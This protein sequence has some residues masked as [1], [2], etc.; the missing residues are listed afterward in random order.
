M[1]LGKTLPLSAALIASLA[2][3]PLHAQSVEATADTYVSLGGNADTVYGAS[4]TF[5]IANDGGSLGVPKTNDRFAL[6]R[7]DLS[8]FTGSFSLDQV[9]LSLEK[10]SGPAADFVVYAIPDLGADE[11]FDETTYTFNTSSYSTTVS[12]SGSATNDGGLNKTGLLDLGAFSAAADADSVSFTSGAM[13]DFLNDDT[14]GMATFVIWQSTQEKTARVFAS[15]EH[16]TL[17]GPTLTVTAAIPE[18]SSFALIGGLGALL[19]AVSRR[20]AA[21]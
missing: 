21:R 4:T 19:C 20:R 9:S 5:T 13:V 15:S 11:F 6:F 16:A 8:A 17:A 18:P 14:N 2:C 7:F 3:A 10:I 1:Q 12:S